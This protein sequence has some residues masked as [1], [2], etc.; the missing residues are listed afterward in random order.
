MKIIPPFREQDPADPRAPL[1]MDHVGELRADDAADLAAYLRSGV[2]VAAVPMALTDV[3]GEDRHHVPAP[4]LL[5]DGEYVWRADLPYY[6]ERYRVGLPADFVRHVSG[7]KY[8]ISVPPGRVAQIVA[9][10][11]RAWKEKR[12]DVHGG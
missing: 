11:K 2:V 6:V 9:E 5:T 1:M 12:P 4:H 3:L 7:S 10:V 8:T